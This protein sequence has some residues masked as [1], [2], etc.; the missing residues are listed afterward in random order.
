MLYLT[1]SCS[2]WIKRAS[3]IY[4]VIFYSCT[5]CCYY[6]KAITRSDEATIQA[7]FCILRTKNLIDKNLKLLCVNNELVDGKVSATPVPGSPNTTTKD[8]NKIFDIVLND[9]KKGLMQ[10]VNSEVENLKALIHNEF[11]TIKRSIEDLKRTNFIT[12]NM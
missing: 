6:G 1:V 9:I 12:D 7:T 2:F 8:T 11:T 5:I 4:L 10:Q 3:V